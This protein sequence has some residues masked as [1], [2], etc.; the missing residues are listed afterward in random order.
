M[1]SL[2]TVKIN[3]YYI[4]VIS[5]YSQYSKKNEKITTS[6]K[7]IFIITNISRLIK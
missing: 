2:Y 3:I 1:L 4:F 7:K 6:R 5:T